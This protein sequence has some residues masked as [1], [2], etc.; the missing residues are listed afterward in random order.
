MRF[1][2]VQCIETYR[3]GESAS[4]FPQSFCSK[5]CEIEAVVDYFPEDFF[6]RMR[7]MGADQVFAVEDN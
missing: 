3:V 2:C 1:R 5:R 7:S 4:L 6:A